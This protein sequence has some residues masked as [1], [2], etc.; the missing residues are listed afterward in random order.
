LRYSGELGL[1]DL[2]R[3][4]INALTSDLLVILPGDRGTYSELQLAWEYDKNIF[5]FLGSGDVNGRKP[6]QLKKQFA[7]ITVGDTKVQLEDWL[8]RTRIK[9]VSR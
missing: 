1:H 6:A 9:L 8:N 4:H 7:G 5:L 2:S 3:N